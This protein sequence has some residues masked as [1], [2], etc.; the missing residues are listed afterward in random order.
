MKG[1]V[2]LRKYYKLDSEPCFCYSS[3]LKQVCVFSKSRRRWS[4]Y[5]PVNAKLGDWIN[6]VKLD[7]VEIKG[8][9]VLTS[10]QKKRIKQT[11][12]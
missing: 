8:I 7:E 12:E 3:Q 6:S 11:D 2:Q 1:V 10:W 4:N 9:Q 5:L